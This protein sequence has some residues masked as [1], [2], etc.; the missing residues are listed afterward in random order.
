LNVKGEESDQQGEVEEEQRWRRIAMVGNRGVVPK[1]RQTFRDANRLRSIREV[2]IYGAVT[3][4]ARFGL[5]VNEL[6][7]TGLLDW[8]FG[9]GSLTFAP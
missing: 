4:R 2:S 8:I 6:K 3:L 5:Q 9:A 7:I 1:I